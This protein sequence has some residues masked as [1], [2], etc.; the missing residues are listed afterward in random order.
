VTTKNAEYKDPLGGG[1]TG[2]VGGGGTGPVGGGG[3]GPVGGGGPS[4]IIFKEI[5]KQLKDLSKLFDD[6][7][8]TPIGGGAPIGRAPVKKKK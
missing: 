2:P 4:K 8:R 1:G 5:A 7:A 6:L 3:T